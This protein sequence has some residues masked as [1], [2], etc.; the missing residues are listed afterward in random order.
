MVLEKKNPY[1]LEIHLDTI[2]GYILQY[3]GLASK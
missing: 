2:T 3:L 1:L